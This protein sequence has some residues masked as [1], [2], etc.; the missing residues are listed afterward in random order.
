MV[1]SGR[2]P[3]HGG[4]S[5]RLHVLNSLRI[6]DFQTWLDPD[7]L[8]SCSLVFCFFFSFSSLSRPHSSLGNILTPEAV[9]GEE[10]A[11]SDWVDVDQVSP[12]ASGG[13]DTQVIYRDGESGE[14]CEV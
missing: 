5:C 9:R 2:D 7:G 3:S 14:A 1:T 13:A 10:V 8:F 4:L 11:F 12:S 6:N